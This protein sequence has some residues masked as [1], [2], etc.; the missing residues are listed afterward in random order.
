MKIR[1]LTAFEVPIRLRKPIRHASYSRTSNDTLIVRCEL[2]DGS[3]GW[4]EG[5]PRKY[6]TGESIESVWRH[7]T[8]TDFSQIADCELSTAKDAVAAID[9]LQLAHHMLIPQIRWLR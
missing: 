9:A 5:L 8:Q 3:V 6:V 2:A 4:G 7:L 1:S